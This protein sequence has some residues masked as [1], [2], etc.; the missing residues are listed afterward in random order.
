[1]TNDTSKRTVSIAL[2]ATPVNLYKEIGEM[3]LDALSDSKY[4]ATIV[5][6]GDRS[7]L[8]SE[9]LLLVGDCQAFQEYPALLAENKYNRPITIFWLLD[10]LPPVS[11]TPKAAEI[12]S[13]LGLYNK[14]LKFARTNFKPL[15]STIPIGLRR[16]LGVAACAT[17]MAGL[18]E[19]L[20]STSQSELKDLDTTSRYELLGRYEWMRTNHAEGWIDHMIANT[21]SKIDFLHKMDIPASFIPFGYHKSMG[22]DMGLERDIDV[23]FLGEL[24]YGRRKPIVEHVRDSLKERGIELTIESGNCY[25]DRRN[26]LLSRAKIS[27]NVP[28]FN[29]DIPTIRLFMSIGCGSLVVSEH[30]GDSTPFVSGEHFVQA[31]AQDLPDIIEHYVRSDEDRNR[32]TSNARDLVFNQLTLQRALISV[33]NMPNI[34][35]NF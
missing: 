18:D 16:K 35:K 23:L 10:T 1:M 11:F 13:R 19:E 31:P 29:W 12:G 32:V 4:S 8:D 28:R 5:Q 9:L 20:E 17:L 34:R 24:A 26:E 7:A 21:R 14:S 33:L 25:G 22:Q 3:F 27:L 6:D 2:P 30:A 15:I